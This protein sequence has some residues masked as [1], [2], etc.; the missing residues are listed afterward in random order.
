MPVATVSIMSKRRGRQHKKA[1][2]MKR[3]GRGSQSR[4][5]AEGSGR[6][7]VVTVNARSFETLALGVPLRFPVPQLASSIDGAEDYWRRFI[8]YATQIDD[9]A[10]FPMFEHPIDAKKRRVCLRY[11][12]TAGDLA[13]ST[14]LNYPA[15]LRVKFDR[16]SGSEDVIFDSPPADAVAGL[17]VLLRHFY[18]PN[19]RAS[20]ATVLK[21]L[22]AE[23]ALR[24]SSDQAEQL[25]QLEA[26]ERAESTTRNRSLQNQA[27][28][29]LIADGLIPNDPELEWYPDAAPPEQTISDYFYGD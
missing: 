12:E 25:R 27:I 9:P 20:F 18:S 16:N 5:P 21:L 3:S 29:H 8:E 14:A 17:T 23:A 22:R 24:A 15:S 7:E 19:E 1:W 28:K 6:G 13:R 26:W 10:T 11:I 4:D 2:Q